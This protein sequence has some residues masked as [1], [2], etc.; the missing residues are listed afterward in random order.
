MPHAAQPVALAVEEVR[1]REARPAL[2]EHHVRVTGR[3]DAHGGAVLAA[4]VGEPPLIIAHVLL[5][6][7]VER[8]AGRADITKAANGLNEEIYLSIREIRHLKSW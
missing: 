6:P 8:V 3:T 4:R 2:Q 1:A 7:H 5:A